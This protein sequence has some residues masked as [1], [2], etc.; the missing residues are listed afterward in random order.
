MPSV[1]FS[2]ASAL[3]ALLLTLLLWSAVLPAHLTQSAAAGRWVELCTSVGSKTL[4]ISDSTSA[5]PRSADPAADAFKSTPPHD[6][7][8]QPHC[9]WCLFAL[10]ALTLLVLCAFFIPRLSHE[11]RA[12][13]PRRIRS[14]TSL[15]RWACPR[16]P[17][18]LK[19]FAL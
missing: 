13:P 9:P 12:A 16:A 10:P 2:F 17:P 7:H 14:S 15:W 11:L 19:C 6:E 1:R 5:A 3:N 18:S 4:W 8:T